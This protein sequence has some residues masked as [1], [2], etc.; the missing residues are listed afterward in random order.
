MIRGSTGRYFTVRTALDRTGK[1]QD[2]AYVDPSV[3][4]LLSLVF[5]RRPLDIL[6]ESIAGTRLASGGWDRRL[7]VAPDRAG[8]TSGGGGAHGAPPPRA[9]CYL[10][11]KTSTATRPALTAHGQPA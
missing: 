1:P 10:G 8:V 11:P 9:V 4:I 6:R 2:T 3:C 5:L 7:R